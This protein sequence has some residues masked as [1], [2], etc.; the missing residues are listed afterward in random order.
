MS[1]QAANASYF[2][3]R[4]FKL[5][6]PKCDHRATVAYARQH[7]TIPCAVCGTTMEPEKERS[8]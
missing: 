1:I 8:E 5:K 4:K 3:S 7:E 2:A 6:C